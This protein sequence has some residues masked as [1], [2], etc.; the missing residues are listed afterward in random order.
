MYT[1][2]FYTDKENRKV[3][4]CLRQ[5][6]GKTIKGRAVCHTDDA[7]DEE[8]GKTLAKLRCDSELWRRKVKN[9]YI[10]KEGK[11]RDALQ[12]TANY[13]NAEEAFTKICTKYVESQENLASYIDKL[14][15]ASK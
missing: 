7:Y 4:L 3:V 5:Y 1:Y 9:K 14:K 8:V 6:K 11:R 13:A 2:K 12:A 15:G 10:Y